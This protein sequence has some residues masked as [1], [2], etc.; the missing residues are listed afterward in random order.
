M[1]VKTIETTNVSVAFHGVEVLS[2]ISFQADRGD[3]IA[4]VGPNGSG[5]TTLAKAL[6]GL[7]PV[8]KGE[9]YLDGQLRA[10][11]ASW[12][13]IGYL[14]QKAPF[15]GQHFP[16]TA[17]ELVATGTYSR[18]PFP[19]RLQ[20]SDWQAVDEAMNLLQIRHLRHQLVGCLSGGQLQR[21]LLARAVV[22]HPS[23][24]ILDE[25]IAALDPQTRESFYAM[26]KE[27]NREL[28][29]TVFLISHDIGSCGKY[30][31]KILYIDRKIIFY[32]SP[33]EFC[34]SSSM[35][36]YFSPHLQHLMC[37]RHEIP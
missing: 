3:Y 17:E 10:Q 1:P 36:A 23:I 26:V 15:L 7:V 14:P 21:V 4:V 20:K 29:V 25:P 24:L 13:R 12:S 32:G 6:L 18:L 2:N 37:G 5:K 19:K 35:S 31:S 11:F 34:K 27:M 9:I 33:D 28:Q 30:A 8:S 22:N 16:A